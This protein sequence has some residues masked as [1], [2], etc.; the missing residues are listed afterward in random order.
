MCTALR[1]VDGASRTYVGR[2]LELDLE[3][4]YVLAV[5]PAGTHFTSTVPGKKSVEWEC[6]HAFIGIACPTAD[7]KTSQGPPPLMLFDGINDAG[8]IVDFNAFPGGADGAADSDAPAVLQA[9]DLG[10]W[11]LGQFSQVS[12]AKAALA[13][14]AVH[15]TAMAMA[16]NIPF[17]LHAMVTD[18][19][20]D[21]I[22][23]EWESGVMRV[24]DNPVHVM[25]NP[26]A[27]GWH[28]T[29]LDNWT[30]LDNTDRSASTFG[31]LQAHQPD[32]GIATAAL[33]ASNT[34]IGRFIRAAYYAKFV[35]KES[36]PD[37]ALSTLSRIMNNFDR[38]KGATIDPPASGGEGVT[39]GGS[40]APTGVTTE[41]TSITFMS[42]SARRRYFV[43][44]YSSINWSE[45][46]L[47]GLAGLTAPR[48][49]PV[50]SLDPMGGEAN[51]L[52][53]RATSG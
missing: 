31:S 1:Y 16:G 21:S 2:T 6:V 42:D 4:P 41:Y 11:L 43:R 5:V 50:E 32:S 37:A 33:P 24:L 44:S 7:P 38:P 35:R 25:T 15:P 36:D 14:Q 46:Q 23:I 22:V 26:P 34:S 27:L 40:S 28:L 47:D 3:M 51:D 45:F 18:A 39:F 10:A 30:H 8:L 13:A 49:I 9:S 53:L 48:T 12:D 17:P 20:G 52:F 29:N 19:S